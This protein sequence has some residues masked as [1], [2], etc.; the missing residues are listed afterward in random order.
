MSLYVISHVLGSYYCSLISAKTHLY[1]AKHPTM[2]RSVFFTEFFLFSQ[3]WKA[4]NV[5]NN[6]RSFSL[7]WQAYSFPH[8]TVNWILNFFL[9]LQ[10]NVRS[11]VVLAALPSFIMP[12]FLCKYLQKLDLKN[13]SRQRLTWKLI[14]DDAGKNIEDSVFKFSQ[15][16][17]FL[18]PGQKISISVFFSSCK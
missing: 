16:T 13:I 18:D 6:W 9:E 14:C 11:I 2:F 3:L 10:K 12:S 4:V 7:S 17:G 1:L 8:C 5:A 15:Q